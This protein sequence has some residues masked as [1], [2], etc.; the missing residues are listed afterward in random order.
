MSE[1]IAI[2]LSRKSSD[3]EALRRDSQL[4]PPRR[5]LIDPLLADKHPLRILLVEDNFINQKVGLILLARLGYSAHLATDGQWALSAVDDAQYDL[6]LMDIQMPNLSGIDAA[7][8]IREKLGVN[9]PQIF[10]MTAEAME[11]ECGKY[12]ALGFDGF[13]TKPFQN[14]V[15]QEML[16]KVNSTPGPRRHRAVESLLLPFPDDEAGWQRFPKQACPFRPDQRFE[17]AN[18]SNL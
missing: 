16:P 5:V 7:R 14:Q 1:Q 3:F 13:L 4:M 10:A 18:P 6:I 15:L 9:C 12:L 8:L 17:F 11:G 2:S